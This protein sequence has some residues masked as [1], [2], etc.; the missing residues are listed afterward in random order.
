MKSL[1]TA[2]GVDY[3]QWKALTRAAL[4]LDLRMNSWGARRGSASARGVTV[5]IGQVAFYTLAGA[6]MA[7]VV[8]TVGDAFMAGLI[9]MS[10][11]IVVVG[12]ALLVDH[13]TT[14]ISPTDYA[15]LGY[16]PVSSRTYFAARL[17]NVLVYTLGATTVLGWLPVGAFFLRHGAAVGAAATTAV[18]ACAICVTLA[19]VTAY[20]WF[21]QRLGARRLQ[22]VVSY[23]QLATGFFV[24]GAFF[25]LPEFVSSTTLA[26]VEPTRTPWLL[27]Y[28][29][30]WFA[31]YIDVATGGGGVAVVLP[32]LASVAVVALLAVKLGGRLSLEYAEHLAAIT[33]TTAPVPDRPRTAAIAPSRWFRRGEGRAVALLVRSHF[34]NDLKFRMAVL[35]ILPLTLLYLLIGLRNGDGMSAEGDASRLSMI[36][37][38]V[39]LFPMMLKL[40]MARSEAFQASWIFFATPTDRT[41]LVRAS[42]HV[43]IAFFVLPYLLFVGLTLIFFTNSH[44]YLAVYLAFAGMLSYLALLVV[45]CI[46]PELPFAKPFAKGSASTRFFGAFIVIAVISGFLP[47]L[48]TVLYRSVTAA[49]IVFG[50]G[51]ALSLI[52]GRITRTRVEGRA[53]LMEFQG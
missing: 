31:S 46:D 38:A 7:Y 18:Y 1:V 30:A 34:R 20:L 16:L 2:L 37:I 51:V 3:S 10:Y 12:T 49:A 17:T 8:G 36:P 33:T 41:R 26:S 22:R 43:L 39:V 21:V 6:A 14:V 35:S 29:G 47:L 50:S 15:I 13:N 45:T 42:T 5:I 27:L 9:V 4:K 48:S 32:V 40:N 52:L 23:L 44:A 28:P 24:Y 11:V 25:V 53:A 19:V